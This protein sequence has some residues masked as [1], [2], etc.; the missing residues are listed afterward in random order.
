MVQ[1]IAVCHS[2]K[3]THPLIWHRN[4]SNGFPTTWCTLL[5]SHHLLCLNPL[6]NAD[7]TT[8]EKYS[9]QHTVKPLYS[10]HPWGMAIWLLY[11]GG[12][13][14]GDFNAGVKLNQDQGY[15][16]LYSRWLL[17]RGGPLERFHCKH[18]PDIVKSSTVVCKYIFAMM[19][20]FL[21]HLVMCR[22]V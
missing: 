15:W 4:L 8:R 20:Q 13:C 7:Y 19:K 16:S 1:C 3:I 9:C 17:L 5:E 12:C 10:G 22:E 18:L 21:V 11:G 2:S 6:L 14:R